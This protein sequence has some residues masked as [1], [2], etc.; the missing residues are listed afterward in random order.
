MKTGTGKVN[1][2]AILPKNAMQW[3]Q[4]GLEQGLLGSVHSPVH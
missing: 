4:S 1:T 3:A 2:L